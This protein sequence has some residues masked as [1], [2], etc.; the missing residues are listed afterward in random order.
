MWG[1]SL[2]DV[3]TSVICLGDMLSDRSTCV[4]SMVVLFEGR[5]L[6]L[7][8]EDTLAERM[9]APEVPWVIERQDLT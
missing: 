7:P 9:R 4:L 5:A 2:Q 8:G 6:S 3:L 1:L